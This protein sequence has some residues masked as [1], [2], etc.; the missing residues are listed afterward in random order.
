MQAVSRSAEFLLTLAAEC[1][2]ECPVALP[3]SKALIAGQSGMK[4]ET[5][6]WTF[7]RLRDHSVQT[8]A[9]V[10]HIEDMKR[11]RDLVSCSLT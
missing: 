3:C 11:L 6:P 8:D 7:N 4:P 1:D 9:A 2:S 5:L 10:A